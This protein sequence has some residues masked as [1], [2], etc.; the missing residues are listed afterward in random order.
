MSHPNGPLSTDESFEH[1]LLQA[2]KSDVLPIAD[3][4][5]WQ[6]FERLLATTA[7]LAA[8]SSLAGTPSVR[9]FVVRVLHSLALKWLMLGAVLGSTG[10]WLWLDWRPAR[11]SAVPLHAAVALVASDSPRASAAAVA[12]ASGTPAAAQS[13]EAAPAPAARQLA[14]P[15]ETVHGRTAAPRV[16]TATSELARRERVSSALAAE[17]LALDA[18]RAAARRGD[19]DEALRLITDYHAKFPNGSLSAD[20]DAV[21]IETLSAAGRSAAAA[22]LAEQ[23]LAQHPNDPHAAAVKRSLP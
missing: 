17:V 11:P 16:K 19:S 6:Q 9:S 8:I 3:E 21:A 20:A 14:K 10:T 13:A 7:G 15:A 23:F 18:A 1:A 4:R 22:R 2:G 12:N 5:A